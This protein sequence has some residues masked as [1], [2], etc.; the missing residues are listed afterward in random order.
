M[1]ILL[2]AVFLLL[3]SFLTAANRF[4]IFI[5]AY[6]KIFKSA[7]GPPGNPRGFNAWVHMTTFEKSCPCVI[8]EVSFSVCT[9][10]V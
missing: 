6:G 3:A 4:L 1:D 8:G 2:F 5:S 7:S 10:V 9:E